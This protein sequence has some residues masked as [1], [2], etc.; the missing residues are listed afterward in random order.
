MVR[1]GGEEGLREA[2]ERVSLEVRE[3]KGVRKGKGRKRKGKISHGKD[4]MERNKKATM[5]RR[6]RKSNTPT[7][8][9][10]VREQSKKGAMG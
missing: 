4:R 9:K 7:G 8:R 6:K 1:E 3:K 5:N 10:M 2:N